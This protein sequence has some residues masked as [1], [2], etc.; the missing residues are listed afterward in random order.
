MIRLFAALQ[1]PEEIA[2]DLSVRQQGLPG[3]RWR[4]QDT[5]HV[6]LAFYDQVSQPVAAEIDAGLKALISSPFE[7]ELSGVGS[8]GEG[9]EV[10]AI[11]AGV[12]DCEPLN[13]LARQAQTVG[14]RAGARMERRSFR[15]HVTLAYLKR[16]DP[17]RVA[18]WVGRH[19][20][21]HSPPFRVTW[22]GLWSS[23]PSAEGS[24]Y[25]LERE[26]ALI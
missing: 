4:T 14:R 9:G 8:F 2:G 26:Y 19:N 12:A 18:A 11:W 22:F 21:L 17:A 16:P 25:E 6:T 24:R 20:L 23:W 13:R 7:I 1:I 5:L 10:R 15:P 3:A